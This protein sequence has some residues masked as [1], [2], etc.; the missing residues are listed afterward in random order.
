VSLQSQLEAITQQVNSL[1][2]AEKR[3]PG[4]QAIAELAA[5]GL[6]GKIL[7]LGAQAP[8]F[9]LPDTNGTLVRSADLL[10]NGKLMIIFYR[11]RWCPYCMAQLETWNALLPQLQAASASLV[12]IS[13]QIQHQ[14]SLTAD[15]HKLHFPVLSDAG[16]QVARSFNL[17]YRIPS[18]LEEQYKR[19]FINLPF[20]NGDP[21]WELPLPATYV[22]NRD[23]KVLYAWAD[24][25]YR[26]RSEPDEALRLAIFAQSTR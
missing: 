25:D 1:L 12:A 2:P 22:L 23:G 17:V 7:S 21:G 13:P 14:S 8:A 16:N 18:Y 4:E 15:Q 11:G 6:A 24:A 10:A 5:S 19:T 20:V 26:K 9:E 3:A